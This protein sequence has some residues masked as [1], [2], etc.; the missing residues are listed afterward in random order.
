MKIAI[1]Q[2]YLFPY[3]GYLQL[4]SSVDR[5]VVYDD[6]NFIKQGWINRNRILLNGKDSVFSVPLKNA[7][8][9]VPI[10]KTGLNEQLYPGWK[11]KFFKTLSQ[12]YAKA[13]CFSEIN[14]MVIKVF[15]TPCNSISE[16]S[17]ASLQQVCSYLGLG[18]EFVV[19]SSKYN[20][21]HLKAQDRVIDIC[22]TEGADTY[23]NLS[24][25]RELYSKDAFRAAG[26]ELCFI[27]TKGISYEQFSGNFVPWL[28]IIDVLMFNDKTNTIRLLQQYELN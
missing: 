18:T 15:N 11:D 13:P 23:I 8:S 26:L 9:F 3:I 28:S 5:F 12:A 6:V 14:E 27:D 25:G 4:I 2:P 19:T 7:S 10:N 20:N 22:K 24:G 21:N 1:M 17:V 16:L